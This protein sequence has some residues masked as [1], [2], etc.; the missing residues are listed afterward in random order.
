MKLYI[1][2]DMEGSTGVV[3]AEQVDHRTQHYKFGCEMQLHDLKA[4]VKAAFHWGVESIVVND[5]HWTMTNLSCFDCGFPAEVELIS[6]TPKILGMVEGVADAD[7]A[8]FLGYHA[9]PGT[10][11]AVLDH[12]Y[13]SL[14]VFDLEV[15]GH[16]MGETGL[17]ALLCGAL[18]VP[19][20][21]VSGDLALC[22][23]AESILGPELVTCQLKDGTGRFSA[24]TLTPGLTAALLADGCKKALDKAAAGKV[25]SL[26]MD[27]PYIMRLTCHSTAQ[28]D[29]ASLVPGTDRI[30]GRT[31]SVT[32]EDIFELRRYLCSWTTSASTVGFE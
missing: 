6:G 14:V 19:V 16:R 7:V 15:N 9:M 4:V 21:L 5:A 18:G 13:S 32:T 17:N 10:E 23:E 11:K 20:A 30:S 25:P 3:S 1:S 24:K 26:L 12:A 31:L 22:R 8:F 2:S 29:A 28:A 27:A